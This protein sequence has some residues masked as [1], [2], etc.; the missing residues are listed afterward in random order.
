MKRN[1]YLAVEGRNILCELLNLRKPCPDEMIV[2]MA[3]LE[4]P[5]PG[6][7]VIIDFKSL[8]PLENKL[9]REYNLEGVLW[10][11]GNPPRFFTRISAALYNSPE[12]YRYFAEIIAKSSRAV[13]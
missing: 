12:Q 10:Y 2:S 3:T 4:L 6:N 8:E 13:K 1:H 9:F 5:T 11:W 7:P